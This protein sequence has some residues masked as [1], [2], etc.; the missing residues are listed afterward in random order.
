MLAS[1][2]FF[3]SA[4]SQELEISTI[5][6]VVPPSRGAGGCLRIVGFGESPVVDS[7]LR[8]NDE[9]LSILIGEGVDTR[10][11]NGDDTEK[12]VGIRTRW[13][14]QLSSTEHA[15]AASRAALADADERGEGV[16]AELLEL[17]HSG[18]SSPDNLFP[19]C[20]CEIQGTLG[21]PPENCEAR[22][23]S[24]ACA[25]WLDALIL[26]GSRMRAKGMRYGLVAV[27]ESIGNAAQRA[28]VAELLPM[29][30]RGW[31]RRAGIQ[32]ARRSEVRLRR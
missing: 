32:S 15:V 6:A 25:S 5:P 30:R 28:D 1:Q 18:G 10:G 7:E 29:G 9:V 23:V 8:T 3:H 4:S 17:V 13:W 12:L 21:V 16:S 24:L 22:D 2:R 20:A 11:K 26:A 27:G 19:A 31:C 14:S